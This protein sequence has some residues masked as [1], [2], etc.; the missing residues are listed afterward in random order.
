MASQAQIDANRLNAQKST[1]A[2]TPEG[3]AR[4]RL[5]ATRHALCAD[6]ALMPHEEDIAAN[7]KLLHEDLRLEHHPEGPTEDILVY[8]MAEAFFFTIRAQDMLAERLILNGSE[9]MQIEDQCKQVALMLRYHTTADR[10]FNRNL[11]DLRKLQKE[12]RKE[13]IGFVSQ[14]AQPQPEAPPDTPSKPAETA[15]NTLPP[16][17]RQPVQPPSTTE[18][19]PDS[20]IG[21]AKPAFVTGEVPTQPQKKAA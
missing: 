5:N 21:A 3:K 1:G 12:R 18:T 9:H 20:A 15:S 17:V 10:S 8:K 19:Q 14:E 4:C 11:S 13:P 2:R 6:I 16:E 7:F